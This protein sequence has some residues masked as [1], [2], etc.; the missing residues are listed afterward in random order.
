LLS[1]ENNLVAY[2]VTHIVQPK[3]RV[4]WYDEWQFNVC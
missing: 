4:I 3:L 1:Q 2:F